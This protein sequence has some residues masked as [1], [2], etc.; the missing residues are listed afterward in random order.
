MVDYVYYRRDQGA[1]VLG[2]P[3]EGLDVFC[4]GLLEMDKGRRERGRRTAAEVE[5]GVEVAD[6]GFEVCVELFAV[7]V[8]HRSL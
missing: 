6:A 8:L 2:A 3:E 4:P 1:D 7:D 5:E